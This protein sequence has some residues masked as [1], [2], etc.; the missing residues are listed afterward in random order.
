MNKLRYACAILVATGTI[1]LA[2]LA[3][4]TAEQKSDHVS[5]HQGRGGDWGGP[6]DHPPFAKIVE[7]T[8]DQK[9]ILEADRAANE[10]AN[11]ELHEKLRA[12]HEA[13]EKAADANA[14]D[15]ELNNLANSSAA[16]IAQE[17]VS[18]VKAHRKFLSILTPEQKQKLAQW[19]AEHKDKIKEHR[20]PKA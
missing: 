10:P 14:S 20:K 15:A 7:L 11:R 6:G 2:A 13:L 3:D 9:K 1:S 5:H 19:E 16:L 8:E 17:E 12:A 4:N 18:R